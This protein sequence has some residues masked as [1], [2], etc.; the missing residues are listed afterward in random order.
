MER[1]QIG[2]IHGFVFLLPALIISF[3]QDKILREGE[4]FEVREIVEDISELRCGPRP[5]LNF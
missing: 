1:V 3:W 5:T 4:L 2:E